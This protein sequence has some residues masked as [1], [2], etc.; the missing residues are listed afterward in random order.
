MQ[1]HLYRQDVSLQDY[2]L[3]LQLDTLTSPRARSSDRRASGRLATWAIHGADKVSRFR[4]RRKIKG[5]VLFCPV[6]HLRRE[7]EIRFLVRTLLGL[8]QTDA[9]VLCLLPVDAPCR[10]ELDAQLA[11]GGR[12]GQVT[13]IDPATPLN[14]MEARLRWRA[15][16]MRGHL[17]LEETVQILE[18][19]GLSP[20]REV[21]SGF[22]HTASFVEAWERLA[23]CVEF[24]AV[25]VRCHWNTLCS[26]VCRTARQRGK[27][28]ITFQQGV[29]GHTLDVP[30]TASKYV[31][32]GQSSASFLAR[33][34]RRFFQ[35]AGMPEPP[36]EYVNGGC[37]FDT[38]TA[39]P[40]QFARQTLLMVDVPTEPGD[41]YGLESQCQALLQL[42]ER[43]LA[44]ELPLLRL[45][46]R[47]HPYWS[48][49]D[50]QL[51]KSLVR[52]YSTRCELSHPAWSLED[53]LRRS[54]A[55]VGIFSGVLTVA[56]AC[57]LPTVFLE[58]DGGYTTADLACFSP[59]QTLLPDAAFCAL[60]KILT[61]RQAYAE[62][63]TQ[64][65]RNAREYY[66][67]G[68]SLKLDAAF[69]E[70]LLRVKPMT[71]PPEHDSR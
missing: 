14:P 46:I 69:F 33:L 64:A 29:V 49:L 18:P 9:K 65:L 4:P 71:N 70:S 19:H 51:C 13:F 12:S 8:A 36:V 35:S 68:T 66:A 6:P 44:A 43:L 3:P 56:S 61:D 34:N 40:D 15:A 5:D 32:F 58:T 55:V 10:D 59:D 42:A 57:G 37:L 63:Q 52:K 54:S 53:D 24:D 48:N 47:P 16:R 31:A 30:V 25:V 39:L 20:G 1:E 11:A 45:V 41:F 26:P 60:G 7:T 27:P 28:V 2:F 21:E 22:E 62:A 67:N 50:F 38:V 17:A 23:P